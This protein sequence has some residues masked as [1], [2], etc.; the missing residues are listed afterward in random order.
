MPTFFGLLP[1]WI[2]VS[3]AD[4][5]WSGTSTAGV[6]AALAGL[7]YVFL[8]VGDWRKVR[9]RELSLLGVFALIVT[10]TKMPSVF[11]VLAL[12]LGS[13]VVM[14]ASQFSRAGL[15]ATTL[16][17]G[18]IVTL[19]II[20]LLIWTSGPHF[21]WRLDLTS[22]NYGLGQLSESGR[23]FSAVALVLIRLPLWVLVMPL[24]VRSWNGAGSAANRQLPKPFLIVTLMLLGLLL[25]L[26]I[27]GDSSNTFLYLAGPM[28]FLASLSIITHS[29]IE[30][31]KAR[32]RVQNRVVSLSV[33]M[34]LAFGLLWARGGSERLWDVADRH[35]TLLADRDIH[36]LH[37]VTENSRVGATVAAVTITVVLVGLRRRIP[38]SRLLLLPTVVFTFSNWFGT[39]VR[40]FKPKIS[41][42]VTTIYLGT[43]DIQTIAARL[44]QVSRESDLIATNHLFSIQGGALSDFSL[45]AWSGREFLILG[46]RFGGEIIGRK[47]EA[48]ENSMQFADA[49]TTVTCRPL[50]EAG[51]RWFIV[52]LQL[53]DTRN[54]SVCAEEIFRAGDFTLLS[55]RHPRLDSP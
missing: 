54:W 13:L 45:A 8:C 28:Y 35:A 22:V 21:G 34:I 24:V 11:S 31:A 18:G 25:E 3:L 6:Y 51:V 33:A 53:T 55:M 16:V 47:A 15:R 43:Q 4:L 44:K 5:D 14:V 12:L 46:P 42:D 9:L 7:V 1:A 38:L 36:L 23:I 32:A 30:V 52:D 2:V 10:L 50:E 20:L 27:F 49:P 39:S 17:L 40:D 26:G 41:A 19:S 29:D 48:I 37:Y